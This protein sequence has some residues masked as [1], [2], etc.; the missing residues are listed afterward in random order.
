MRVLNVLKIV[1]LVVFLHFIPIN[2]VESFEIGG[3]FLNYGN[4]MINLD[5]VTYV[6]PKIDYYVTLAGETSD[7]LFTQYGTNDM[8]R[9]SIDAVLSWFQTDFLKNYGYYFLRIHGYITFDT[10]TL[11]MVDEQTFLKLPKNFKF[12][13]QLPS[14]KRKFIAFLNGLDATVNGTLDKPFSIDRDPLDHE[15]YKKLRI[16]ERSLDDESASKIQQK[17]K[18]MVSSY[19]AIAAS[20]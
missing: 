20:D 5:L 17:I 13:E 2:V 4:G 15:T 3:R 18:E 8:S 11:T 9:D 12:A 19:R 16:L 7:E 10:F 6:K 14:F 1:L